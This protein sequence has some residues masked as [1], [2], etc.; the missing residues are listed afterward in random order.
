MISVVFSTPSESHINRRKRTQRA[1]FPLDWDI[2]VT[3]INASAHTNTF[4]GSTLYDCFFHVSPDGFWM[5]GI[6]F[7]TEN[8]I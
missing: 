4:G 8:T 3:S 7:N 5:L 1:L 6:D 2:I